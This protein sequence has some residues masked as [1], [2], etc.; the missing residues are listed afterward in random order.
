M[1]PI[2]AVINNINTIDSENL[3]ER[4]EFI[5][6]FLENLKT[7][8]ERGIFVIATTNELETVNPLFLT[9][10]AI[11]KKIC[12]S[13]PN[14]K[15][16]EEIIKIHLFNKLYD[17]QINYEKIAEITEGFSCEAIK[18]VANEAHKLASDDKTAISTEYLINS[19]KKVKKL[20]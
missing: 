12:I 19:V 20:M 6:T 2:I 10:D 4:E 7:C 11:N 9:N 1:A 13:K 8:S 18:R 5:N 17:P 14:I 16:R 15:E 3:I